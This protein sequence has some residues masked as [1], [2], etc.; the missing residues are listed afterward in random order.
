MP[1]ATTMTPITAPISLSG[2]CRGSGIAIMG[3]MARSLSA[4]GA[5]PGGPDEPLLVGE[6]TGGQ[7]AR[8]ERRER[9]ALLPAT[10]A[11]PR[12]A[13]VEGAAAG[14]AGRVRRLARQDGARAGALPH[15]VRQRRRRKQRDR[16]G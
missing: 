5:R 6:V 13:G 2:N 8:L 14:R 12:T 9:W 11:R 1:T 4:R 16:V 3:L 15:R 10:L 7:M